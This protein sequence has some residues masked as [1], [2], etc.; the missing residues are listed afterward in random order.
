[1]KR[2]RGQSLVESTLV[3][4]IFFA[5]LFAVVDCG[6]IL[7]THQALVERVRFAVRWGSVH[8]WDGTGQQIADLILYDQT[9]D[10]LQAREGYLGLTRENVQVTYRPPVPQRPDDEMISVTIVDYRYR[11][12]SPWFTSVLVNPRPVAFSAPVVFRAVAT[13]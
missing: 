7:V 11:F 5:F 2:E 4:L 12:L 6:Q 1:M 13:R 9:Q 8:G 10:P 3:L